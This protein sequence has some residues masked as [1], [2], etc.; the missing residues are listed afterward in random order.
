MN[1]SAKIVLTVIVFG[2]L[3]LGIDIFKNYEVYKDDISGHIFEVLFYVALISVFVFFISLA[4]REE[5]GRY[6]FFTSDRKKQKER[7]RRNDEIAEQNNQLLQE[8]IK[9][10]K[11]NLEFKKK[12]KIVENRKAD[13]KVVFRE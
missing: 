7:A 4:V 6:K 11:E 5:I 1:N 13:G 8:L 12:E 10:Q 9:L 2:G 3:I